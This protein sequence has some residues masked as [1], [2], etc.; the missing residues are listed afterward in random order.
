M[1]AAVEEL[2]VSNQTSL[3]TTAPTDEWCAV[4][5]R[6]RAGINY[7]TATSAWVSLYGN[8]QTLGDTA[9]HDFLL[10]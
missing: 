9:S 2:P 7:Q 3:L 4:T 10:S 1:R 5:A 6:M 8:G